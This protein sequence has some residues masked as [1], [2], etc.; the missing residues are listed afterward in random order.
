M[1]FNW[2]DHIF[3]VLVMVIIPVMSLNSEK[4]NSEFIAALPPKKHLFYTNGL[5]LL[6]GALLVLTSWNISDRPWNQIGFCYAVMTRE[7]LI[8]CGVVFLLY[9]LDIVFEIWNKKENPD[10]HTDLTYIV[11]IN[12]AEYKHFIF[13]AV[14]AGICEEIIF[15]GFLINYLDFYLLNVPY[16]AYLAIGLPAIVFSVSH[17]YQGWMAVLKIILLALTFGIL[18]K[19]SGSLY[20]VI[21]IHI[22]IDLISGL[23]SVVQQNKRAKNHSGI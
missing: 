1:E 17:V 22:G 11:P 18:Y 12:W 7:V 14:S 4:V 23:L 10:S 6:I 20:P 19:E 8:L 13:L 3:A 9:V 15:R 2:F 21:L 5:M 16:G